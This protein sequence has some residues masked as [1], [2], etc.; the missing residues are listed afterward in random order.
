MKWKSVYTYL[1][2]YRAT[3][4][5]SWRQLG[6]EVGLHSSTFTRLKHG[7]GLS[8][9]NLVLIDRSV[10]GLVDKVASAGKAR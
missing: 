7:R 3:Q 6:R 2:K 9:Q 1:D 8:I 4:G 5:F 10:P